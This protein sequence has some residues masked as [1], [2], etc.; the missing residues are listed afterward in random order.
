MKPAFQ[1][2][3]IVVV[4]AALIILGCT[5]P[6][7]RLWH[8][9]QKKV[10]SLQAAVPV[11][12]RAQVVYIGETHDRPRDHQGQLEIIEAIHKSRRPVAIG[13]EMFQRK[14]Q[15]I[16]DRWVS[17]E[18]DE[19]TFE[20]HFQE[21][22]GASWPLY[23]DIFVYCRSK[24][25]PMV[26]LNVPREITSQ[27]A[28]Q[29]FSSLSKDQ[30]GMLPTVTCR[31]DPEYIK[32]MRGAHGHAM[33]DAAF[34]HFCE[35]QLV[36]DTAMATYSIEYLKHYPENVLVVLA[37]YFHAWK[38]G[39]PTQVQKQ[40]PAF[41]QI[42]ILPDGSGRFGRKDASTEDCDYLLLNGA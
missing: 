15:P 32:I 7:F 6:S 33:S 3:P 23:R 13:L 24:K 40:S 11:L 1:T 27:V 14:N 22:W 37:G 30:V 21:N 4:A 39:I 28:Q 16:L 17:G 31:V 35:A 8:V 2:I 42:V 26:G 19:E 10:V 36:W 9:G 12:S 34:T 29:G 25:I 5:A 41:D 20:R 18:M 38:K